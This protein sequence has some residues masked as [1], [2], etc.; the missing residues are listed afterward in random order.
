MLNWQRLIYRCAVVFLLP[1]ALLRLYWRSRPYPDARRRWQERL[2]NV[3][4]VRDKRTL[5]WIHAVS[6]GEVNAAQPLIDR[7]LESHSELRVLVT[8]TTPTGASTLEARYGDRVDH[9]YFPYDLN[10]CLKRFFNACRPS[11]IIL[12]ETELWPNFLAVA[13]ER[14]I[15]V[16][17]V[18]GRMSEKALRRYQYFGDL[19]KLMLQQIDVIAA[20]S[21]DDA[22]RF[23][24]LGAPPER[25]VSTGSLK[26][27]REI[28]PSVFERGEA[29]KRELGVNRFVVMA[30]STREGEEELLVDTL[31]DLTKQIPNVLLVLAPR[32]PE[33]FDSVAE[34]LK[35]RDVLF[36]RY[37]SRDRSDPQAVVYLLDVMG[38]L[39]NYYAA[40]DL[41]FVGGSLLPL[42]GQNT[43][44]PAGLGIPIVVGPH[45]YNFKAINDK[46]A[47]AGALS[48]AADTH[49]LANII[50]QLSRDSNLRDQMGQAARNVFAQNRGALAQVDAILQNYLAATKQ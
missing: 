3:S 25:V 9:A 42:G 1:V 46:L 10:F 31:L 28:N 20:Q 44:E 27:D 22:A 36:N 6:V 15:P 34:L 12:M 5:V 13:A 14:K 19:I 50:V 24:L 16:L 30:G 40:S 48:V 35:R 18:N 43:L 38:E 2:G 33:R 49:E 39:T 11:V 8:T 45:T 41:A 17:L 4:L 26:F 32:H 23:E 7:L 21:G 37:Q 47:A 29:L